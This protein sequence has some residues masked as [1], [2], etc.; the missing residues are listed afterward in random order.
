VIVLVLE[1][2]DC[3]VKKAMII[4]QKNNGSGVKECR[5]WCGRVTIMVG[6]IDGYGVKE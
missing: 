4:M 1:D 3:G 2:N 5:L 6:K